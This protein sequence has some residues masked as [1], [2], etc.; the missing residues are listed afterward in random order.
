MGE[1]KECGVVIMVVCHIQGYILLVSALVRARVVKIINE[2][3]G[4]I[5]ME[6]S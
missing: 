2:I 4:G 6:G 3:S 5:S 1:R